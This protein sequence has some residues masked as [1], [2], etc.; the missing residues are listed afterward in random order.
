MIV[1]FRTLEAGVKQFS[2]HEEVSSKRIF[3]LHETIKFIPA[4]NQRT[5]Q[6]FPDVPKSGS[7]IR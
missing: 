3:L 2:H 6:Q 1:L 7:G 5:I 4:L